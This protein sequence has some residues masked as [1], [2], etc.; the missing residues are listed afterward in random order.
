MSSNYVTADWH[1]NHERILGFERGDCGT[2]YAHN[3][4]IIYWYNSVVSDDDIVYV[5]GDVGFGAPQLLGDLVRQLHG[6][7]I[8][9]F[10]NHDKFSP[11]QALAMGFEQALT[12]PVYYPSDK[13]PGQIILSHEPAKE[14]LDNHYVINVH[15]HLH[16]SQLDLPNFYN[17]NVA[18]TKYKPVPMASFERKCQ[19]YAIPRRENFGKEWY[20]DHYVWDKGKSPTSGRP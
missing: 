8:L 17:V 1:F 12:G 13:C 18:R 15:G 20:F 14:A 11:K 6:H 2:M 7:K 10:G 5:L 9:V 16:N 3:N 4:R 19:A